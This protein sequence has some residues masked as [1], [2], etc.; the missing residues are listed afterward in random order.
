MSDLKR[1]PLDSLHREAG[2]RMVPFAGWEMPVMYQSI[3]E[4]H[5][6]VR[7]SVGQFDISHMGQLFVEGE[8][9]EEWL[10][11]LLTNDVSAL[12]DGQG[13]YTFLLNE[14][15]GVIDDLIIYRIEEGSY[16]LVVNAACLSADLAW[17]GKHAVEGVSLRDESEGLAGIAVQ[18]PNSVDVFSRVFGGRTLPSRNGIDVLS[19]EGKNLWI[20]RTG[21]TGEDGFEFFCSSGAAERWWEEFAE[22]G[23]KP[24][25]LGSRDSLRLEKCYPLNGSDL[26]PERT[27][28]EAGLGFFVKLDK[29]EFIG[30]DVLQKQKEEKPTERLM[31]IQCN[32][33]GAPPRPGYRVLDADG[34]ALGVLTSGVLSPILGLGIGMAYLPVAKAKVGTDV[35]IESR[36]KK[37]PAKVVKKPFVA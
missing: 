8:G 7:E 17:F 4:E 23:A 36:G 19:V 24:C 15:G 11:R 2:G 22:A 18:G 35:F 13:Q 34:E 32:E 9:A 29:G 25:G 20:C 27:P 28:L 26:T 14:A 1:S 37:M 5:R 33:K 10:N 12:E 3:L 6:A 21:Y 16:F 31:A 30:S